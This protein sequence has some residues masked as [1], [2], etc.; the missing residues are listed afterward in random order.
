M[1]LCSTVKLGSSL[2]CSQPTARTSRGSCR[3]QVGASIEALSWGR[4]WFCQHACFC[5]QGSSFPRFLT[6]TSLL[7]GNARPQA[8][9]LPPLFVPPVSGLASSE[10]LD[11]LL[12]VGRQDYIVKSLRVDSQAETWNATFARMH[13]LQPGGAVAGVRNFLEGSTLGGAEAPFGQQ[14]MGPGEHAGPEA[15]LQGRC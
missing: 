4:H 15:G 3:G 11:N 14:G 9:K 10:G 1:S 7:G 2:L 12:L 5:W 8:N 13:L 6:C